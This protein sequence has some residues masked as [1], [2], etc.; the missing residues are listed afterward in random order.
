[1]R[2]WA[3]HGLGI[4][5]LPGFA[6]ADNLRSGA[7][8]RPALPLPDLSLRLMWRA[9]RE[10]SPGVRDLRYAAAGADQGGSTALRLFP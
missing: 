7:P 3:E 2:A 5:L 8:A 10:S 1:M 9:D 4:T 6:V